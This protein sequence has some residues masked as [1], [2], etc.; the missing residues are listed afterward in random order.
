MG[1][2]LG[3]YITHIAYYSLPHARGGVSHRCGPRRGR[4]H[5]FPTHVGVF[6]WP[7]CALSMKPRLPH[8]R[9]GVSITVPAWCKVTVSSPRTWGCFPSP[10]PT[11]RLPYVFPTHVGVFLV[12]AERKE[13]VRRLP[14]ARGG[15]SAMETAAS[16][17][18][19]S[20][21][22]T[23]G[24]FQHFLLLTLRL[25]VFPTHVGVFLCISKKNNSKSCLPH[26][27]GGVSRYRCA[28]K[29]IAESSPRTWGCFCK[30]II[31]PILSYVFPTHVGVF[32]LVY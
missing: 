7:S 32:L 19:A 27:R 8:A 22:R 29:L 1:V 28:G 10:I 23:W 15:V 30:H 3:Y 25:K 31:V 13:S 20:S 2:F 4:L 14:H 12:D 18:M 21:P 9:G 5:V 16:T 17:R 24:C 11:C 6:L 26:A